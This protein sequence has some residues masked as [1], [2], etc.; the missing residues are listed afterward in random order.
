MRVVWELIGFLIPLLF[1]MGIGLVIRA[2]YCPG[3]RGQQ[4]DA[5]Y[6]DTEWCEK[7]CPRCPGTVRLRRPRR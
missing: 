3:C 4:H 6:V 5:C 1:G 7:D 2:P